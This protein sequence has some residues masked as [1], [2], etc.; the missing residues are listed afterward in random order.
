MNQFVKGLGYLMAASGQAVSVILA[1]Y[2]GGAY[3]KTRYPSFAYWDLLVWSL[4]TLAVMHGFFV[5]IRN[6]TR[7]EGRGKDGD[8]GRK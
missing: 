4:A 2:F 8:E 3:L 7:M 6:Y 5:I 1:A